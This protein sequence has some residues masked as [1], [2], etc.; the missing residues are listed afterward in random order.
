MI[1][2]LP[3][4]LERDLKHVMRA[5]DKTIDKVASLGTEMLAHIAVTKAKELLAQSVMANNGHWT[6]NLAESISA[7]SADTGV[8]GYVR[9][10]VVVNTAKA[11]YA[12]WIELGR[13]AQARP[14]VKVGTKDYS[15]SRFQGY[16]YLAGA[17]VYA[18]SMVVPSFKVAFNTEVMKLKTQ[19]G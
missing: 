3:I 15:Q 13:Y 14:Y 4:V 6:G 8:S 12:E 1:T 5:I 9:W 2:I 16:R 10:D 19:L 7:K 18:Q 17:L 11:P